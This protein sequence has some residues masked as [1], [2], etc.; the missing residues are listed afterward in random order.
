MAVTLLTAAGALYQIIVSPV[1]S[2]LFA[3]A[4]RQA[5][6]AGNNL[7]PNARIEPSQAIWLYQRGY[8]S[9]ASAKWHLK[10]GGVNANFGEEGDENTW[11]AHAWRFVIEATQPRLSTD[12]AQSLWLKN[13]LPDDNLED[14]MRQEGIMNRADR[15][16]L[17]A[18][19]AP[20][21]VDQARARF[22]AGLITN[23][24]ATEEIALAGFGRP[25]DYVR[26]WEHTVP[27]SVL[28]TIVLS[29]RGVINEETRDKYLF[30]H[31][32][33]R[34]DI[35]E[36]YL[37]AARPLPGPADLVRFAVR[38]V[39]DAPTVARFSYDEEFPPEFA[40]WLGW[41]GLNWGA[42]VTL[43]DGR[44]LPA[45][46]WPQ[47]YWRAHWQIMS[48]EQ[49]YRA[50]HLLRPERL[51]RYQEIAPGVTTFSADD[52]RRVL[53][54]SDYPSPMRKWL[55]AINTV[56]LS[57]GTIRQGFNLGTFTREQAV[58]YM[59]DRGHI[60]VDAVAQVDVWLR[61]WNWRET[62]W[63]RSLRHAAYRATATEIVSA[64]KDGI[65][66]RGEALGNL[67]ALGLGEDYIVPALEL[68]DAQIAREE[69]REVLSQLRRAWLQGQLTLEALRTSLA[70][71]ELSAP[72]QQRYL[73]RWI[74]QRGLTRR[75]L[76]ASQLLG[77]VAQGALAP[78]VA[79]AGLSNLNL[80]PP[81]IAMLLSQAS[82]KFLQ[83]QAADSQKVARAV[84]AS[85]RQ[86]VAAL[87]QAQV[88]ARQLRA[89]LR[90]TTPLTALRRWLQF[91]IRTGQWIRDRMAL[92]G[93]DTPSI[94]AYL[95]QWVIESERAPHPEAPA[96]EGNEKLVRRQT[97]RATVKSWWQNGVV[98]DSWARQRLKAMGYSDESITLFIREWGATLGKKPGPHVGGKPPAL[99]VRPE[100]PE[101][102]RPLH[103]EPKQLHQ[104]PTPARPPGG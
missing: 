51:A 80:A 36:Q 38:E 42:P 11:R 23:E 52:L 28:D 81:D 101:G 94:S 93:Y 85:Q 29:W 74:R 1:V 40:Y 37:A 44:V 66:S 104:Q 88:A 14:A 97:S 72:A 35:R 34:P 10:G 92:L 79:A 57:L 68:A 90:S 65:Q 91:G 61:A 22:F 26:A 98:T 7:E 13:L 4:T 83:R 103:Q 102:A 46:S 6:Y 95:S 32:A 96:A 100:E 87:R 39:W 78:A 75:M 33:S 17:Y 64:Y 54:V 30:Y 12:R 5:S 53:K 69:V 20:I 56:P 50:Y 15:N 2:S 45:V 16:A 70:N 21:G 60:R 58:E 48:P 77:A 73:R 67:R 43:H 18:E 76:S 3:G 41:V 59:I 8:I 71:L 25:G 99:E 19:R 89:Q 31:G 86:R 82:A 55:A 62:A 49:S 27:P 24:V 47:A 84:Q 63:A 9:T